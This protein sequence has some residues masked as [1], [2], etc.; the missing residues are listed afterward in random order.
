MVH[1]NERDWPEDDR[2]LLRKFDI[3][4]LSRFAELRPAEFITEAF[5]AQQTKP[6]LSKELIEL[7]AKLP[8]AQMKG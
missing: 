6:R 2:K 8:Q 5:V 1:V 3:T 4:M 7:L